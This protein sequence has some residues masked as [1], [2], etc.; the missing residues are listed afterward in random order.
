MKISFPQ[1]TSGCNFLTKSLLN[2]GRS[3]HKKCLRAKIGL[4]IQGKTNTFS[5][6]HFASPTIGR[7]NITSEKCTT[8]QK[9]AIIIRENTDTAHN[10]FRIVLC[11]WQTNKL[12]SVWTLASCLR[13]YDWPSK[14]YTMPVFNFKYNA[15]N[16]SRRQCL[17]LICMWRHKIL[18]SGLLRFYLIR[19]LKDEVKY[20]LL[21][22]FRSAVSVV[23][24]IE[25][26][27]FS[28]STPYVTSRWCRDRAV[29]FEK[30]KK[31][32]SLRFVTV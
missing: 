5:P 2:V 1:L 14:V 6:W 16:I 7:E 19:F 12:S 30:K 10:G 31:G 27:K 8:I 22:V 24:K 4:G 20:I 13:W 21:Y 28:R 9:L 17:F 32:F 26:F 29:L 25:H 3:D 11:S 23:F 15:F 18:K